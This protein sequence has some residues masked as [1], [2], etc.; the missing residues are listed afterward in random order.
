LIGVFS[1]FVIPFTYFYYEESDDDT[2]PGQRTA[3]ALKYTSFFV[4]ISII[5]LL[6]GLFMRQ[7]EQRNPHM[8][9]DWFKHLLTES[10]MFALK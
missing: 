10:S 7:A 2:T 8:D 3:A 4:V 5:L 6:M 1:F 9:L